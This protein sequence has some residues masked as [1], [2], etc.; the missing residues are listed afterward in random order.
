MNA[1]DAAPENVVP[2]ATDLATVVP[3]PIKK[4]AAEKASRF[5]IQEFIN[6]SGSRSWRVTGIKRDKTR[7]RE[8]FTDA[9]KAQAR[10]LD[11]ESEYLCGRVEERL[12]KTKLTEDQ[13]KL[14]EL[15]VLR[16]GDD[17][18]KLV[19]AVDYWIRN[20]KQAFNPD[21]P[22]VDEALQGFLDWLKPDSKDCDLADHTR[23][24]Y[25]LRVSMFCNSIPNLR[26]T[27]I[28][29]GTIR[30]YL[31]KRGNVGKTT[32]GN[33]HR[34]IC[35]FLSWCL[36]KEWIHTNPAIGPRGKTK[37]GK[38]NGQ[39]PVI[40]SLDQCEKLLRAAE[41]HKDGMLA[42]YV[43]VCLFAGLR[44]DSEAERI[45]WKQVNL[46]DGQISIEPWMTKTGIP[47]TLDLNAKWP[48]SGREWSGAKTLLAWLKAHEGKP[49]Y[50]KGWRKNFAAVKKAAGISKWIVDGMRHTA[51]SHYFR[52]SGSYGQTAE[53]F[54]NQE[55]IVR[56]HYVNRVTTEEMK[57]FYAL[58]PGKKR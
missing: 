16:L 29:P 6:R 52:D 56:R 22:R 3:A 46:A 18:A 37:G 12:V 10:Q 44:P 7:I 51:H 45:T 13:N 41:A 57:A 36:E 14:A 19:D 26:V 50:P 23:R 39:L 24:G 48:G 9:E 35:R 17:W 28:K 1:T 2:L 49:F 32:L 25:R 21:A 55:E 5:K 54:G 15:A 27:D 31:A 58:R 47:R 34:A 30:D 33:D 53:F 20:G 11:L 40:L 38:R 43:A 4:K 8:N 42:P